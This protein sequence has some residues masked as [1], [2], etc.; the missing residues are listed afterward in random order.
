M[1]TETRPA[2]KAEPESL[3]ARAIRGTMW[4]VVRYLTEYTLRL[5]S[6]LILTRLLF[7]EAFGLLALVNA[8]IAGLTMLSDV[9]IAASVVQNPRGEEPAFLRTAWSFQVVRGFF[10][11]FIA[12]S[13]ASVMAGV[14]Q[15]PELH[16][17]IPVAGLTVLMAG[18]NS[19][20]LARKKRRIELGRLAAIQISG[21]LSAVIVMITWSLISPSVWA[22]VAGS[23]VGAFTKLLLSHT[24]L[25]GTT[26]RF[27][28][29]RE[30]VRQ[31]F[32]FGKWIFV[33]TILA[34]LAGQADRL[35]F[36]RLLPIATL[37]VYSIALMFAAIPTQLIWAIGNMVL[38]PT[39]SRSA[40]SSRSFEATYRSALRPLYVLGA[41]PVACLAAAGPA[42][43]D[44]LYDPRYADAGWMLQPL[45]FATWVQILQTVS[46]AALMA[47]G[48]PRRLALGNGSKFAAMLVLV[49][50][51][52]IFFGP[53]GGIC[54]LAAAETFRYAVLA[55]GVRDHGLPGPGLDFAHT[56]LPVLAAAA[57][58]AAGTLTADSDNP[59]LRLGCAVGGVLL[60][61]LPVAAVVLRKEI[62]QAV[63][64][65]RSRS[66]KA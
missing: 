26:L 52:F 11:W 3:G 41:L 51:G 21:R 2:E 37:G 43:I 46:G 14:Y 42:L 56:A 34:F 7:P 30:S 57:G 63:A 23:L 62:A 6:N 39:F 4:T 12:S 36:G 22:L 17:L 40:N 24:I 13:L 19:I 60:L 66:S 61:W 44:A 65:L 58:F 8:F 53:M 32:D 28:W 54:G 45:A 50:S 10:L 59:W 33:S 5:G 29:D 20:S 49:P 64:G 1:S 25:G 38:F 15:Q 31:L 27:G 18:F 55:H 9:G 47:V 48:E 16:V 35:I